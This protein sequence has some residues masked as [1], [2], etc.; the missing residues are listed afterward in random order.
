MRKT[1]S[2]I[3][4]VAMLVSSLSFCFPALAIEFDFSVESAEEF[5][6]TE[7]EASDDAATLAAD[8]Q[9]TVTF[10]G[11]VTNLP[12][13]VLVTEGTLD[14]TQYYTTE[15]PNIADNSTFVTS[16]V[17]LKRFNGWTTIEGSNVPMDSIEVTQDTTV[18]AIINY[19]FNMAVPANGLMFGPGTAEED[20]GTATKET[21][22]FGDV[23]S[24]GSGTED[25]FLGLNYRYNKGRDGII[26]SYLLK[27]VVIYADKSAIIAGAAT[28]LGK[29][30]WIYRYVKAEFGKDGTDGVGTRQ[31]GG[32]SGSTGWPGAGTYGTIVGS[33]DNYQY[34][35]STF[36]IEEVS[37]AS[38]LTR[39][40]IHPGS[41]SKA[42][43]RIAIRYIHF[44]TYEEIDRIDLTVDVPKTGFAAKDGTCDSDLV[45]TEFAWE[46]E[47]NEIN[48]TI[49]AF[50]ENTEY[51]ATFTITPKDLETHRI[52]ESAEVYLNGV[53]V[54]ID[55]DKFDNGKQLVITKT[56]ETTEA[57][58]DFTLTLDGPAT[59]DA[60]TEGYYKAT[61]STDVDNDEIIWSVD[62]EDVA[63][64]SQDGVL[65]AKKAGTVV[66]IATPVYDATKA[67]SKTVTAEGKMV[68][69]EFAHD[70]D[71]DK[72][73]ELPEAL[74]LVAGTY[75][76]LGNYLDV[77]SAEDGKRFNGWTITG[78]T[79]D[80]TTGKVKVVN[81]GNNK[82]TVYAVVNYDFNMAIPAN[83]NLV[84]V[85]HHKNDGENSK[86]VRDYPNGVVI[87]S[88]GGDWYFE[89]GNQKDAIIPYYKLKNIV[90]YAE[91]DVIQAGTSQKLNDQ[92][93]AYKEIYVGYDGNWENWLTIKGAKYNVDG[94][95]HSTFKDAA[96]AWVVD[97][98]YMKSTFLVSELASEYAALGKWLDTHNLTY[99]RIDP[100][101]NV[102]GW[103]RGDK[104]AIRYIQFEGYEEYA[105]DMA[106]ELGAPA[107]GGTPATEVTDANGKTTATIAWTDKTGEAVT[108]FEADKTYIATITATVADAS[109]YRFRSD[110]EATVNGF[111]AT[112]A[113]DEYGK[114]ATITATF[115]IYTDVITSATGK[116][117]M[118]GTDGTKPKYIELAEQ[119][120]DAAGTAKISTTY[121][122]SATSVGTLDL[123][124]KTPAEG[125]TLTVTVSDDSLVSVALV[126]GTT[127][128]LTA[129]GYL[130]EV[131]VTATYTKN[132]VVTATA[133]QKVTLLTGTKYK[134]GLNIWTG[135]EE[136][137]TFDTFSA[138]D[139]KRGDST[140]KAIYTGSD[141]QFELITDSANN[142]KYV[143]LDGIKS[144]YTFFGLVNTYPVIESGR[145]FKLN[146]EYMLDVSWYGRF[147]I[148]RNQDQKMDSSTPTETSSHVETLSLS[149]TT[150]FKEYFGENGKEFCF[151]G[152]NNTGYSSGSVFNDH[153]YSEGD[154]YRIFF[155]IWNDDKD[156]TVS[157]DNLEA[158]PYYAITYHY[159]NGTTETVYALP[160]DGVYVVDAN[161]EKLTEGSIGFALTAEGGE[162]VETV[163]L[164]NKDIDLYE[165]VGGI[166][167]AE[168][169]FVSGEESVTV[170]TDG[171]IKNPSAYGFDS[172]N[173]I[174]WYD[175]AGNH[176][177][178]GDEVEVANLVKKTLTAFY[179]T[180]NVPA[181][182]SLSE[183]NDK[184][185]ISKVLSF[186]P[187]IDDVI[188]DGRTVLRLSYDSTGGIKYNEGRIA[189]D[190][191]AKYDPAQYSLLQLNIKH[192]DLWADLTASS[193]TPVNGKE[194]GYSAL[195]KLYSFE[196][197]GAYANAGKVNEYVFNGAADD[198][199][200]KG[201]VPIDDNYHIREID[202]STGANW[203][204]RGA[205]FA[206]DFSYPAN[207][208]DGS[209]TYNTY[210]YKTDAYLDYMRVYR[211]GILTVTYNTN[212]PEGATVLKNVAADKNR[213]AG[214]G[215][216]LKG[217]RP[218]VE[219]YTFM[220]WSVSKSAAAA[221]VTVE[222]IDLTGDATVYASWKKMDSA[223]TK[224]ASQSLVD[225]TNT[226]DESIHKSGFRTKATI[227]EDFKNGIEEYGFIAAVSS[228]IS[229]QYT[230][231]LTFN[232]RIDGTQDIPYVSRAAYK[233]GDANT[234]DLTK[235]LDDGNIQAS[236]VIDYRD[237]PVEY[238]DTEITVRSYAKFKMANG[239]EVVVYGA[240]TKTSLYDEAKVL[241]NS[242][243]SVEKAY[244]NEI[245]TAY[246]AYSAE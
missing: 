236:A 33:A 51:T 79:A 105:E 113:L 115:T 26:P 126:E 142:N 18:Y 230:S 52:S 97:D 101:A 43:S 62:K 176:Y 210:F 189:V 37:D 73:T 114:V 136:P 244:A 162:I 128:R 211:N 240:E 216:L 25:W 149:K 78:N 31:V 41:S 17:P 77:T 13:P 117:E 180:T 63:T 231:G 208:A 182:I 45:N 222:S 109:N 163:T 218:E 30:S 71:G 172:Q 3:L 239:N 32:Y 160:A 147:R 177:Y 40:E 24:A 42:A 104:L 199:N 39:F 69:V 99:L 137:Y 16:N 110:V 81:Q 224:D 186:M 19:D 120:K 133:T 57:T 229:K 116:F 127:Y 87:G 119:Y 5:G 132:G 207:T 70:I 146:F 46:P 91:R 98:K 27:N 152:D 183:G 11:N 2:L 22:Q 175:D 44:D 179:Q 178:E 118:N 140:K 60:G 215:Y 66:V 150:T 243:T 93:Y 112:V 92:A 241:V 196:L 94:E 190:K 125:E 169:T 234:P 188:D 191:G 64:I 6:S 72:V 129:K 14:L 61:F 187:T 1:I 8:G 219:G 144:N 181:V 193:A 164:A 195:I 49:D 173:F 213:G 134:P 155:A 235:V 130:G 214:T 85:S 141:G 67:V 53:K 59:V 151:T 88:G 197:N 50:K 154:V 148:F 36:P 86:I 15:N 206:W 102:P 135:T 157:L 168:V 48:E 65:T 7:T 4:C 83:T 107:V 90:I 84:T 121:P 202:L 221:G 47:L 58:K 12:D 185:V 174:C 233:K 200:M 143:Q 228:L 171:L 138:D 159:V 100:A 153:Q 96:R 158:V 237:V 76:D 108:T 68:T 204:E 226:K 209:P 212:A 82:M 238:Y 38:R 203:N 161:T 9:H 103:P 111:P 29:G 192:K 198:A 20:V 225:I 54:E 166:E 223:V 75:L 124:M 10:V 95:D 80:L 89:I 34:V 165:R 145:P 21:Y 131:D 194:N 232:S 56:F 35:M 227:S 246:D 245:I 74:E 205:G 167:N 123:I 28:T 217:E 242:G 184:D 170:K 23:V 156:A 55:K 220:G 139:I 201:V 106:F 122:A